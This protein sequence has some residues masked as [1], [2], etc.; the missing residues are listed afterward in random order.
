VQRAIVRA[1]TLA[2]YG[3]RIGLAVLGLVAIVGG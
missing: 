1:T 2:L 3:T